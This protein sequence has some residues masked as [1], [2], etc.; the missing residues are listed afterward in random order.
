MDTAIIVRYPQ[1]SVR[2]NNPRFLENIAIGVP[3]SLTIASGIVTKTDVYH[4]ID[5][6]GGAASDDL[7][8][9]NNGVVGD[10]LIISAKDDTHTV[11]V[12]DGTGNL[13]LMG[14]FSLDNAKD[15]ITLIYT[16]SVWLELCR[17]NNGG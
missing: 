2:A 12:K 6:E 13:D 9:I 5:T 14:D 8:T 16:G 17:A 15:T 7:D 10:I 1:G 3:V 11:V 4:L